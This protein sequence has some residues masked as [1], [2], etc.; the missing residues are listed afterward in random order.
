MAYQLGIDFGTTSTVAAVCRRQPGSPHA[1]EV[2]ALSSRSLTMPSVVYL[3][4]DGEVVL[5]EAA[6]R[7][8]LLEPERVVREFKRRIGDDVPVVVGDQRYGAHELAARLVRWVLDLVVE[9]EGEQPDQIT[10]THPAGWGEH[11]KSLFRRAIRQQ[12]MPDAVFLSEPQAA[13][14][15]YANT[16]RVTAGSTLAV[17]DLG[18]GTF[19]AAMVRKSDTGSFE[20]L[21]MP[22]GMEHLGGM[23]FDEAV[24]GHVRTALGGALERL[25]QR[26][27]M[28]VTAVGTLRRECTEAKEALS[29][30]TETAVP[31]LLPTVRTQ[32]RLVRAELE[33]MIR[34]A[35]ENTVE[36]LEHTVHGVGLTPADITAVLLVGGSSRIPLVT[37]L[38][39]ERFMVPVAVDTDPATAV[40]VGAALAPVTD[41]PL[42]DEDTGDLAEAPTEHLAEPPCRP[43]VEEVPLAEGRPR[44]VRGI[45]V[46]PLALAGVTA[47][48]I[49][50]VFSYGLLD[51]SSDTTAGTASPSTSSRS[52]P[53]TTVPSRSPVATASATAPTS[54][55]SSVTATTTEP[56]RTTLE[57]ALRPAVTTHVT[58]GPTV[59]ATTV[60]TAP[61][62]VTPTTTTVRKRRPAPS[63]TVTPAATTTSHQPGTALQ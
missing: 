34:P 9:R 17:Y 53:A 20:L 11:K 6:Q 44:P 16:S 63:T 35:L 7:R 50:A 59:T 3:G 8:V 60:T 42:T 36:V 24:L 15:G 43:T 33:A 48:A 47:A 32:V 27:P 25:D 61:P 18:G 12:G 57:N 28:M 10:I 45:R 2:V 22:Q 55:S 14:L 29:T 4:P 26:D 52:A 40:A 23:D 54:A 51:K 5:G 62:V 38:I 37:Q 41:E 30:D 56:T 19:D 1:V 21:G 31:V 58:A 13:A 39:S 49:L 46:L